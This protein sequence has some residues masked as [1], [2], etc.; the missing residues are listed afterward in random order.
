MAILCREQHQ[1]F[2]R[3]PA[4]ET[5]QADLLVVVDAGSVEFE[6]RSSRAGCYLG[7]VLSRVFERGFN[8]NMKTISLSP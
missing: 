5:R 4:P 2:E 7:C 6:W 8:R 1:I 3:Y